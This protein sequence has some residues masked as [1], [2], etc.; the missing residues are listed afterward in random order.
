MLV[1]NPARVHLSG[2]V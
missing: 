2:C 1:I